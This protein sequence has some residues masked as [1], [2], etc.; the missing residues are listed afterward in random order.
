MTTNILSNNNIHKNSNYIPKFKNICSTNFKPSTTIEIYLLKKKRYKIKFYEKEDFLISK[1]KNSKTKDSVMAVYSY[2]IKLAETQF[3][4]SE[5]SFSLREFLKSFNGYHSKISLATLSNRFNTLKSLGLLQIK[6]VKQQCKYILTRYSKEF[7]KEY[8]LDGNLDGN[9]NSQKSSSDFEKTNVEGGGS[10]SNNEL[11]NS[12][13][14][15][16]TSSKV[17]SE[18]NIFD[19]IEN[20][21]KRY[22][23]VSCSVYAS[24]SQ[25]KKIARGLLVQMELNSNTLHDNCVQWLVNYKCSTLKKKI[26]LKGAV[27]YVRAIIMDKLEL[28][29]KPEFNP[30][31]FLMK[32]IQSTVN[33]TQRNYSEEELKELEDVWLDAFLNGNAF[34]TNN[35][36]DYIAAE[37]E[38]SN[39]ISDFESSKENLNN[40]H[41]IGSKDLIDLMSI[42][43]NLKNGLLSQI[44]GFNYNTYL[45]YAVN[46]LKIDGS[47]LLMSFD[48]EVK[49]NVSNMRG[50]IGIIKGLVEIFS[51]LK[52][53]IQ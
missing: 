13:T 43:S 53:V 2:L 14:I 33:F 15:P 16:F 34:E 20:L 28:V 9:L 39:I 4:S 27:E 7:F 12:F 29:S 11:P 8:N 18:L 24:K 40:N 45:E 6:K 26:D 52:L 46:N 19:E 37:E 36:Y 21:S 49:K 51:D 47:N 22:K 35:N 17:N 42:K 5:L 1:I 23:G 3:K 50:Y 32:S 48:A 30:P 38:N 10:F 25:L 31:I 44:T 41:T